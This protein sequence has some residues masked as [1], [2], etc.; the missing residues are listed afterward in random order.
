VDESPIRSGETV[1][2]S[3]S[4]HPAL[5]IYTNPYRFGDRRILATGGDAC[6]RGV[7]GFTDPGTAESVANR[8]QRLGG[9]VQ[10]VVLDEPLD[11]GHLRQAK[12]LPMVHARNRP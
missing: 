8:I 1:T 4:K 5:L 3:C 12:C 10:Y 2:F 9:N 11:F 6:G 7:E